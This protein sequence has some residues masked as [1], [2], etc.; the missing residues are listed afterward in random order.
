MPECRRRKEEKSP[1]N[2][3]IEAD[4]YSKD[5]VNSIKFKKFTLRLSEGASLRGTP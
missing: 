5:V 3:T 1:K 2:S 4:V